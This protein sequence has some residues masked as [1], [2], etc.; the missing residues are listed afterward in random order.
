[1]HF[2]IDNAI[3]E[4]DA[5]PWDFYVTIGGIAYTTRPIKVGD[6]DRLASLES[7]PAAEQRAAVLD[8]FEGTPPPPV[9]EWPGGVIVHLLA[10]IVGYQRSR[11]LKNVRA[12][13]RALAAGN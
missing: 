8:L 7:R 5:Q 9:N 2:N 10:A 1:M 13:A 6:V 12:V 3:A 11:L 4:V